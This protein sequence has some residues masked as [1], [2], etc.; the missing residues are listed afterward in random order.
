MRIYIG[1]NPSGRD[2]RAVQVLKH[3]IL[4]NT[5]PIGVQPDQ[6]IIRWIIEWDK[7][8]NSLLVKHH[9]ALFTRLKGSFAERIAPI[10]T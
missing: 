9:S 6:P 7:L 8:E 3:S 5:E 1:S 2:A 10:A 4:S